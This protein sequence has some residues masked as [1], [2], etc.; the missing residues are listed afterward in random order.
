M[1]TENSKIEAIGAYQSETPTGWTAYDA[2]GF[3]SPVD[4]KTAARLE[5]ERF[6]RIRAKSAA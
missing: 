3:T 2:Q 4:A 1:T 6:E 5:A